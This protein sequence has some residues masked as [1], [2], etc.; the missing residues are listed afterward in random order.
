MKKTP[1]FSVKL[2]ITLLV[3]LVSG[4]GVA[5]SFVLCI[6]ADGHPVFEQSVAGQCGFGESGCA[7]EA[8]P[9]TMEN[10]TPCQDIPISFDSLH[11]RSAADQDLSSCLRI[12]ANPLL[13][14]SA[15][16]TFVRDL[17]PNLL[18]QPPPRPYH[19]LFALRSIILLN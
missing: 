4:Q 10:G 13:V 7:A 9:L 15:E 6:G 17:T 3:L 5:W 8:G 1:P 12:P 14:P 19:A 16:H 18:S 11:G 2:L